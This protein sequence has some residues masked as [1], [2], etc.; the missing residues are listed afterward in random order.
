MMALRSHGSARP[1]I[2]LSD[3]P[4]GQ[5]AQTWQG[6][7]HRVKAQERSH[8]PSAGIALDSVGLDS[9]MEHSCFSFCAFHF[10]VRLT[11]AYVLEL[12]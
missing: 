1:L 7:I 3:G 11:E 8:F 5:R 2:L 10:L 9:V 6:D 12:F 4:S